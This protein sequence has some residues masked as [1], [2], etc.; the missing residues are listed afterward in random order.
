MAEAHVI[1]ICVAVA[2]L[3]LAAAVLG[4]VGEATKSKAPPSS[5]SNALGT[6]LA[7]VSAAAFVVGAFRSQSGERRRREDGVETY[8]RCTVLVAGV[9]AGASSLALLAA[10]VG[11]ASYVALEA[12]AAAPC[13]E[14]RRLGV[15]AAGQ[16]EQGR[17]GHGCPSYG[18]NKTMLELFED[19]AA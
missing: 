12:A 14:E 16:P 17:R 8:Y 9:F 7:T 19:E 10:A 2:A 1:A 5:R 18:S 4:V 3:A 15:A 13:W 6:L 11:I